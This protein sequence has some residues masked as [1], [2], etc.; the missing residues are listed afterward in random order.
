MSIFII[1]ITFGIVNDSDASTPKEIRTTNV[2]DAQITISWITEVVEKCQVNYGKT[3]ALGM[4][5]YDVRGKET[6]DDTHYVNI[7]GLKPETLYYFELVSG[8]T[9]D[10]N[11]GM[12]YRWK[13]GADIK[14]AG[15]D[16]AYGKVFKSDAVTKATGAIVYFK[17]QDGDSKGSPGESALWSALVDDNGYWSENLIN[18]RTQDLKEFFEYSVNEGDKLI[19]YGQGAN[20]GTATLTVFTNEDSPAPDI[21]LTTDHIPPAVI[22]TLEIKQ[23]TYKSVTLKWIAPGDDGN[24]EQ[25]FLYDIRWAYSEINEGNFANAHQVQDE[26]APL[27]ANNPQEF[28]VKNLQPDTYYY[29]AMKT[30][31]KAGN[32]SDLSNV[33]S[34]KTLPKPTSMLDWTGEYNFT[35]DALRLDFGTLGTNFVYMVKYTHPENLPPPKGEPKIIIYKG[36]TPIGTYSTTYVKGT[37]STG[38]IYTYSKIFQETGDYRYK[39]YTQGAGGEPTVLTKGPIVTDIDTAVRVT[40]QTDSQFTVSWIT[41]QPAVGYV[42]YGKNIN[43][44]DNKCYDDR[45]VEFIGCTHHV[46]IKSLS[47]NEVYYF[48]VVSD[49]IVDDNFGNHYTTRTGKSIITSGSDIVYGEVFKQGGQAIA[50]GT[51][52]YIELKDNDGKGSPLISAPASALVQDNGYWMVN[53]VNFRTIDL[54]SQFEYSADMDVLSLFVPSADEG[55]V[56]KI[57]TTENDS[58]ALPMELC[59]DVVAPSPIAT[60]QVIKAGHGSITLK[61]QAT[62]DDKNI[63]TAGIY[64]LRYATFTITETLWGMADE[65]E[66]EPIP[67]SPGIYQEFEVKGLKPGTTYYLGL[68]AI[69]EVW[70]I[71][72]LSKIVEGST[73]PVMKHSPTLEWV[74]GGEYLKDGV[75][76]NLGNIDMEFT[77]KVKYVDLDNDEPKSDEP[78]VIIYKDG[79]PVGT[80]SMNYIKGNYST[81]ATCTF[82]TFLSAIGTYSYRFFVTDASGT[83]TFIHEGPV[84][85]DIPYRETNITATQFTISWTSTTEEIGKVNYDTNPN[86]L[87]HSAND[88]RGAGYVDDTHH[89]TITG[90]KEDTLYYYDVVSGGVV[91]DNN[92]FHYKVRTGADIIPNPGNRLVQ[93]VVYKQG[94]LEYADG[95]I[96][97][98]QLQDVDKEGNLGNSS[99]ASIL[100]TNGDWLYN[101][102]N[103]RTA[104][105]QSFF[106]EY[107]DDK[108]N[109][110]LFA[111]GALDGTDTQTIHPINGNPAP[112]MELSRDITP[113]GTTTLLATNP[114]ATSTTLVWVSAGDD[115]QLGTATSYDIRYSKGVIDNDT[116]ILAKQVANE[117]V[118]MVGGTLQQIIITG[119]EPTTLY[120]FGLKTIDEAG[121][122]SLLVVATIT[123]KPHPPPKLKWASEE[124]YQED[125]LEPEKGS[126]ETIFT[127][128]IAYFHETNFA[129]EQGFPKLHIFKAGNELQDS[130]YPMQE[131]DSKDIE[132]ADGKLYK[133]LKTFPLP[134]TY[135]YCFEAKDTLGVLAKGTPTTQ[136]PGPQ[137]GVIPTLVWT[138]EEGY[139]ADG[140]EPEAGNLECTFIYRVNYIHSQNVPPAQDYPKVYI[141]LGHDQIQNSPFTMEE[142]NTQDTD[143]TDGKLYTFSISLTNAGKY[144]YFFE[145]KD[146]NDFIATG[147]PTQQMTG[148]MVAK[149]PVLSWVDEEG[150]KTDGVEPNT[151]NN[152]TIFTYKVKYSDEGNSP[153]DLYYPQL[154]VLRGG[155]IVYQRKMYR[156]GG[157]DYITGIDYSVKLPLIFASEYYSYYF[158]AKNTQGVLA[159]GT[160][161]IPHQGPLVDGPNYPPRLQWLGK[162]EYIY[163]GL[164]PETGTFATTFNYRI[165]YSDLN[166]DPPAE[167]YP[168]VSI[169]KGNEF[170]GTKGMSY[171]YGSFTS[172]AIY[173][174]TYTFDSSAIYQYRFEVKDKKDAQSYTSFRIGPIVS[175]APILEWTG[176][177]GYKSDGLEPEVGTINLTI[178]TYK[179]VY[180]DTDDDPPDSRYPVV[181][182]FKD[183]KEILGSPCRMRAVNPADLIYDDGKE[184]ELTKSFEEPGS[185]TYQF[186]AY[187]YLRI[188]AIG[189][190]A[191]EISPGPIVKSAPTLNWTY[192]EGYFNDG[193][194]PEEGIL[195]TIFT[196][197][198]N[199]TDL[200]GDPPLPNYPVIHI[201]KGGKEIDNSPF[202]LEE[203]DAKD[204]NYK[205]GKLFTYSCTLPAVGTYSYYF[206]AYDSLNIHATGPATVPKN[207]P[208][209]TE[210][211]I[212]KWAE[213]EGYMNDG[214]NPGTGTIYTTIFT[215]KVTYKD[216]TGNPP[217]RE[218]PKV[219]ILRGGAPQYP[220]GQ[221]MYIKSGNDYKAGVTYS[222][223]TRFPIGSKHYTY[224]FE[225]KNRNDLIAQGPPTQEHDGPIV[226][227]PNFKPALFWLHKENFMSDGVDPDVGTIGTKFTY[228]IYYQDMNGDPPQ[229]GYP[230]IYIYKDGILITTATMNFVAGNYVHGAIYSYSTT[231][232]QKGAYQY[233]FAAKDE[234][235]E[236]VVTFPPYFPMSGP[237]VSGAPKLEWLGKEGFVNDGLEPEVGTRGTIFTYRVIYFDEDNEPPDANYPKLQI[238][239]GEVEIAD[240]KMIE[241]NPQDTQYDDGKI[242]EYPKILT[243][244]GT[245]TYRF[246][247]KDANGIQAIGTPTTS[248]TGPRVVSIP[249]LDWVGIG[250]FTSDGLDPEVGT[251]GTKF[252]FMIK[253]IDLDNLPPKI[254]AP[255]VHIFSKHQPYVSFGMQTIDPFDDDYTDGRVYGISTP[256]PPGT[257]TY[258]FEAENID[259]AK[260]TG[261]PTMWELQGPKV[262]TAP[263]LNWVQEEGYYTRGINPGTGTKDTLFT[264]KVE[265]KDI[266]NE[267]PFIFYPQV[268]ILRDGQNFPGSPFRM[269]EVDTEDNNYKD[270]KEYK[271]S[272]YLLNGINYTYRFVAKDAEG[273]EA[274]GTATQWHNGPIVNNIPALLWA[275]MTGYTEDGL[276]PE[277]GTTGTEFTFLIRYKDIDND[278]PGTGSPK[279][280]I[281][282]ANRVIAGS[283]FVMT[284]VNP[285]EPFVNG[286]LYK[287]SITFEEN[288]TYSYRF[289]AEDIH[290]SQAIGEP[291]ENV[292]YGPQISIL[293]TLSWLGEG[294]YVNSG[295]SPHLGTIGTEF[296]YMID[297]TDLDN[298]PPL[299]D[300]PK[301]D[302]L[303][304]Q[305]SIP[306]SP[307]KM[308]EVNPADSDYTN[309][310]QYKLAKYLPSAGTYSYKFIAKDSTGLLAIGTPTS[311]SQGPLIIGTPTLEWI[312]QEPYLNDGVDPDNGTT[313]IS[314]T[315]KVR[316]I[317]VNNSSPDYGYPKLFVLME[318]EIFPL[319]PRGISMYRKE[320]SNYQEGVIYSTPPVRL[321][322]ASTAYSYY[323]VAKNCDGKVA[324]GT[325]TTPQAGPNVTGNNI[326]PM[327]AWANKEGYIFDGLEPEA[328][329]SGTEF[330][331]LVIYKDM[332][333]D[334][335]YLG[336]PLLHIYKEQTFV[337]TYTME[338]QWGTFNTGA[339]YSYT[340]A[341]EEDG[342]YQYKF[343]AK[344][345]YGEDS[346]PSSP[347]YFK[348][349]PK[350]GAP[351]NL[352]WLGVD[353]FQSD[354]L[355]PETGIAYETIFT[356][357]V[358]YQDDE[359]DPP[360]SGYPRLHILNKGVE[361]ENSPFQLQPVDP[362]D[363]DYQDGKEYQLFKI[364]TS[365]SYEYTY[366]FE[367]KDTYGVYAIGSP[368]YSMKGPDITGEPVLAWVGQPGYMVDGLEPEIG[369][370]EINFRYRLSYLNSNNDPPDTDSPRVHIFKAGTEIPNS[371]FT[372]SEENS[373]DTYYV[374]GKLYYYAISLGTGAY[375]YRFAAESNRGISATGTPTFIKEG[376]KVT[377]APVLSWVDKD[378]YRTDGLHPEA[379]SSTTPF[380]Y[381]VI[382]TDTEPPNPEYPMVHI[383][384]GRKE[385]D[386]SPFVMQETTPA[387]KIYADGKEYEYTITLTATGNDYEYFF[388]AKD[389]IGVFAVGEP[390]SS[391]PNAPAVT[392]APVLTW[393]D[394][395]NYRTDGI[396]PELG[397]WGTKFVY[398]VTYQ[399]ANNDLPAQSFPKVHILKGDSEISGSPF[400]MYEVNSLDK[401]CI[402]GK[403][404]Y[405]VKTLSPTARDYTYFFEAEDAY[406][407]HAAGVPTQ[408]KDSPDVSRAPILSWSGNHGFIEDGVDPELGT[409]GTKF[410]YQVKYSDPDNDPPFTGFPKVHIYLGAEPIENSPFTMSLLNDGIYQFE[411]PLP[412]GNYSYFFEAQDDYQILAVGTPTAFKYQPVVTDAP[413]LD[414]V[415]EEGFKNDGI[416][417]DLGNT[418]SVFTYKIN[419]IDVNNNPPATGYPKVVI[420]KK[421][422]VIGTY[423]ME[424]VTPED[425]TYSDGK[426]YYRLFQFSESSFE[427][428]YKFIAEDYHGMQAVG[429]TQLMN[430]P[431]VNNSP[432][433]H[434]TGESGYYDDGINPN[435]GTTKDEY[436][437]RVKY[438]DKDNH[439]PYSGYPKLYIYSQGVPIKGS[440][441]TM[442]EVD[443]QDTIYTDG[444][445]YTF[446]TN[447]FQEG[448]YSYKFEAK[449][450]YQYEAT[451]KPTSVQFG[452]SISDAPTLNWVDEDGFRTDG[453]DPNPGQTT[454]RFTY[455]VLYTDINNVPPAPGYPKV[456]IYI[457]GI[458]IPPAHVL[459]KEGVG[460]NYAEGIVY[461]IYDIRL[462][463][464]GE[465]Y[466]YYFEAKNNNDVTAVGV[467]TIPHSGPT[468]QGLNFPPL[469]FWTGENDYKDGVE[470]D[471]AS[472]GTEFT[473]H[474]AYMDI[475][476]DPPASEYPAVLIY[477]DD[478]PYGKGTYSMSYLNGGYFK[479][480]TYSTTITLNELGIYKYRFYAK[481][482]KG[483]E[484]RGPFI[485]L[486]IGPKISNGPKLEW[487]GS[488]G[489]KSDGVEPEE[490][491]VR[492]TYFTFKVKYSDPD[493]DPPAS[494]YPKICII[495][496]NTLVGK[497]RMAI[498][499]GDNFKDGKI[500]YCIFRLTEVSDKY[501]YYF[502]AKDT[503]E[504]LAI[505]TP[506]SEHIG[507][508][509]KERPPSAPNINQTLEY[510]SIFNYPNPHTGKTTICAKTNLSGVQVN[511][512]VEIYNIVGELIWRKEE[513][514]ESIDGL[515]KIEWHSKVASGIYIYKVILTYNGQT[516]QKISKMA[517]IK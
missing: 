113:P 422:I 38:A 112:Y 425:I 61:W 124:G 496:D 22:D 9:I 452:P 89:V 128:K 276:E 125:G 7:T 444:K 167:G 24:Q 78:K 472:P 367:A 364:F 509:V 263:I 156:Y 415:N 287:L 270:G 424:E 181:H 453:V 219:H 259:G 406:G 195:Q 467:P 288:G 35:S 152:R 248:Y 300:F 261:Q 483:E 354:G 225:A 370:S 17:L 469:L 268:Y 292:S 328:G 3:P 83:P 10:N 387:D 71:S 456:Y 278:P 390:V 327:L 132:Y 383:L 500:Y 210:S 334:E 94:R 59:K 515:A 495:N 204:I 254:G 308:E 241:A 25:A 49:G 389:T 462:P 335:P 211:P 499:S 245:Y 290:G 322:F 333:G 412:L 177:E 356:Y 491:I 92:G 318:G 463:Y 107:S 256:L 175:S 446:S 486:R 369:T 266:D 203:V 447:N 154:Y 109:L 511:M 350:V 120:Y 34:A 295:V 98:I 73:T 40:N 143:Y 45:G 104:D 168:I 199:Y 449:D 201:L 240:V 52:V 247:A 138:N 21:I 164:D 148:P 191:T 56:S 497:V 149:A 81:G 490:G 44:L 189:I 4:T 339:L 243:L 150:Y 310:K 29:F 346:F 331:Y 376:P 267:P 141:Y 99:W 192:E 228:Q 101:L 23:V 498:E 417:P 214:I 33:V 362:K 13:T 397:T 445:L 30:R 313:T 501:K 232:P 280:H 100:V 474:V 282:K 285:Q 379:G 91:D 405:F 309:G 36:T 55:I 332:N 357:K 319:Y 82:S 48:D 205:D 2:T 258:K 353:N 255:E 157:N 87:S 277:V 41:S 234:Q 508:K 484:A 286:K 185:Y 419:Y 459:S 137:V 476:V 70:N 190:P 399:D 454:D 86:S 179:I 176:E 129:P 421:D 133:Y 465:S 260:A 18:L 161:T 272:T 394:E 111:E 513:D 88:D 136:S 12:Y 296:I 388:E 239:K 347:T 378:G 434:W 95:A 108:D 517:I 512:L 76:P 146:E 492:E 352:R 299:D 28:E 504:I 97:Y 401:N 457:A 320:G 396:H 257:Y 117:P 514:V 50:T 321:P 238:C 84:V 145:A 79:K 301:V 338:K 246:E 27:P 252:T 408:K 249:L 265:Y 358:V 172:G 77:F 494:N 426:L 361:I 450:I 163:D 169:Y 244:S 432:T 8:A 273:V 436:T 470:P 90:L 375:T 487:A 402:D 110:Y 506:T 253:Y 502:E 448:T 291:V 482:S 236:K 188:K 371:P 251:I 66:L 72:E 317:D 305:E 418:D 403:E 307:F 139:K 468:V 503:M 493:G 458:L 355:D 186:E 373:Q 42:K 233:Q 198:V 221:Y 423:T 15:L 60:L 460:N 343:E 435:Y 363:K 121:N 75:Y 220:G 279:V 131:V 5:A 365:S 471:A 442:N 275:N 440:P 174:G 65:V 262:S 385:V 102:V 62:G 187:D 230:M 271:F 193:I 178:F 314:F 306:N 427:Y 464:A 284:A 118:P 250:E 105:L 325:P 393:V 413:I 202:A 74:G 39:F 386:G 142:V 126:I 213:E 377:L 330:T 480:A 348:Q 166:A 63:G 223:Q 151:G 312:G 368:T 342:N 207:G 116:W 439:P 31:D 165:N 466:S 351:P 392:D 345:K 184:Y 209:I 407:I 227:G 212:L 229:E 68:K 359:N 47:P 380:V 6:T 461:S 134:G 43:V 57:I 384:K 14:R 391:R 96:V 430:G 93:G 215:Y 336:Y 431:Q 1:L 323:F 337:G 242:Y 428:R 183:G 344:D 302:I 410:T 473:F 304:N 115:K 122:E 58:P 381:R 67:A 455:K 130:P 231:L 171:L 19:L 103:L 326:R 395:D 478:K 217:A 475:N 374:D 488:D 153:P 140:L 489:F 315:F 297:Y 162:G 485:M 398:K 438:V 411:I 479:G 32:W 433:L 218:Y 160:P 283:P 443:S 182:I 329:T 505:G 316:Y 274:I 324:N 311:I 54:E 159:I 180:K 298:N 303:R 200:D 366:Y 53:L 451:G 69:D 235:G 409:Q 119:L 416:N 196:Y 340:I 226:E 237:K 507:P 158:E 349:G 341:L 20:D 16:Y 437:Y 208:S 264:Y 170:M 477:K 11:N 147:K 155:E 206:E 510:L 382:Y 293:P 429:K 37:F 269:N 360:A 85:T 289:E 46:T 441:I 400:T 123:T 294:D 64:D 173:G 414:W 80:Y 114:T 222:F 127:Y 135:T 197:R 26:P 194:E 144:Y 281:F 404:Y 106:D 516:R 51:I 481:D 216:P 420:F 372:M 224:Y